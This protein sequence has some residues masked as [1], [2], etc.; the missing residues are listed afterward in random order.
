MKFLGVAALAVLL[1][2]TA[3]NAYDWKHHHKPKPANNSFLLQD[4][5]DNWAFV[6]QEVGKRD[7]K[8]HHG[9][10]NSG[11]IQL[12]D[13]N[14]AIVDQLADPTG[15][16]HDRRHDDWGPTGTNNSFVF[17][18]DTGDSDKDGNFALVDQVAVDGGTNN[19]ALVQ[20]GEDN[21]A[22]IGQVSKGGI[23]NSSVAI[24]YG[25]DNHAIVI[26]H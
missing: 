23:T 10:N 6:N 15:R 21:S 11:V 16:H 17:Q 18:K 5:N 8:W 26:Q 25:N 19:S 2:T 4:G 20:V 12:G 13:G 9:T 1:G 14:V 22:L 24:Q 7:N 3:A